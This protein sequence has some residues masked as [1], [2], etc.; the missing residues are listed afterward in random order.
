MSYAFKVLELS[1]ALSEQSQQFSASCQEA[2][3]RCRVIHVGKVA[4]LSSYDSVHELMPSS[5]RSSVGAYYPNLSIRTLMTLSSIEVLFMR[6]Q[7][8]SASCG[9]VKRTVPNPLDLPA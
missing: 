9:V 5:E 8:A 3:C 2:G 4:S 1:A 6:S 7:A